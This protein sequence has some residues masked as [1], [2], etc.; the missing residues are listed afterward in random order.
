[1]VLVARH[2]AAQY[3]KAAC[4]DSL[5]VPPQP[6]LLGYHQTQLVRQRDY[7]GIVGIMHQP[8]EIYSGRF[9]QLHVPAH[10]SVAGGIAV[11]AVEVVTAYAHQKQRLAVEMEAPATC[12]EL[13]EANLFTL[14]I[15]DN[16]VYKQRSGQ[17]VQIGHVW[18]PQHGRV[19]FKFAFSGWRGGVFI[20]YF[21]RSV[22]ESI[23]YLRV[24]R[25]IA[26]GGHTAAGAGVV[27]GQFD[28]PGG[29]LYNAAAD[30]L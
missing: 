23:A 7:S 2:R 30:V 10:F 9:Y 3:F 14:F 24:C 12:D 28:R 5:V 17:C 29:F 18:R 25:R 11:V 21:A 16:A 13:L 1:M 15:G 6:G 26:D 27:F 20:P 8:H 22:A 19:N 4:P